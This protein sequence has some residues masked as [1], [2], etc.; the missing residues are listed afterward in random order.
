MLEVAHLK[1]PD[2]LTCEY[3]HT[4]LLEVTLSN[5]ISRES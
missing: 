2:M 5:L 3:L 4:G 1:G